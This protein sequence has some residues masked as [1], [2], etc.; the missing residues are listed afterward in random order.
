MDEFDLEL[1]RLDE[2]YNSGS[3]TL[4]EYNERLT[5]LQRDYAAMGGY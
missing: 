1:E 2:A 4:T 3:I 5:E